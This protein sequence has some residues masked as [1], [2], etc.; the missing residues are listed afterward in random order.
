M[1]FLKLLATASFTPSWDFT[2]RNSPSATFLIN[3]EPLRSFVIEKPHK[4]D[5]SIFI[6]NVTWCWWLGKI[7]STARRLE[8]EK[9]LVLNSNNSER[10]ANFNLQDQQLKWIC[11]RLDKHFEYLW[12]CNNMSLVKVNSSWSFLW[13]QKNFFI[14]STKCFDKTFL[15]LLDS[16]GMSEF[17]LNNWI[18]ASRPSGIC[19]RSL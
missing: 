6:S 1:N 7:F 18:I 2:A 15:L 12:I 9:D 19:R 11:K 17:E 16:T 3:I 4:G 10:S 13:T 5:D 8:S 14:N